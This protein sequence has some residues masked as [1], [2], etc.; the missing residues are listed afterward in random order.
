MKLILKKDVKSL[1]NAGDVVEVNDGYA[2]NFLLPKDLAKPA[3]EGNVK[4]LN[5]QKK[6]E[7]K[8]QQAEIDRARELAG[9]IEKSPVEIQTKAGEGGRLFGSV[10][11]KE[12]AEE[13]QKQHSIKIDKRKINLK[14]SIK[15][16]GVTD[17]EVKVYPNITAALKV[18]VKEQ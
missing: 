9:K 7:A 11:S 6:A 15:S 14:E 4:N 12:I 2:R 10:T 5:K 16:L 18:H 13:L 1:G 8:K 17:V 3:T